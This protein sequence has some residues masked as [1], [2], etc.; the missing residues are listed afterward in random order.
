M[1]ELTEVL[2]VEEEIPCLRFHPRLSLKLFYF[3]SSVLK[4]YSENNK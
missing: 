3:L 4:H 2:F 1:Y